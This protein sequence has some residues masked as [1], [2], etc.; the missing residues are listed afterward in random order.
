MTTEI[1]IDQEKKIIQRTVT[2]DLLTERS[3]KL[4]HELA[5]HV[6]THKDYNVLMDMRE[7]ETRPEMLDLMQ[8][9][10][11][12]AK[13]KSDFESKIAFLIPNTAERVRFA[14][15]FKSCMVAQGFEFEQFF[16]YEAAIKWL[17]VEE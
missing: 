4:V 9:A 8:I 14:Q 13:L 3:L 15:L 5:L 17:S 1:S 6:S 2:G 11:A 12:C 16:D 7:T 10:S